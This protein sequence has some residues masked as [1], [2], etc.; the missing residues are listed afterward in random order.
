MQR[1]LLHGLQTQDRNVNDH[2]NG[3]FMGLAIVCIIKGRVELKFVDV[4]FA[5]WNEVIC[6]NNSLKPLAMW[7]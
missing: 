3:E 6:T 5:M 2:Y 4:I 1:N 7:V